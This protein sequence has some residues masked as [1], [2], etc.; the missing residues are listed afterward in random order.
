MGMK[1]KHIYFIINC[2]I[3]GINGVLDETLIG[4]RQDASSSHSGTVV[5][6]DMILP[7]RIFDDV[8]NDAAE[9]L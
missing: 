5:L 8:S 4:F 2:N 1:I 7:L 9:Y 6:P 3:T